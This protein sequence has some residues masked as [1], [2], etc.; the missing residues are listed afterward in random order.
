MAYTALLVRPCC[1]PPFLSFLFHQAIQQKILKYER[2]KVRVKSLAS[3]YSV[4]GSVVVMASGLLV[5]PDGQNPKPFQETF[6]LARH[7]AEEARF[8]VRNDMLRV[9]EPLAASATPDKVSAS[10]GPTPTKNVPTK[11]ARASDQPKDSKAAPSKQVAA[12]AGGAMNGVAKRK[13][14]RQRNGTGG[15][16]AADDKA[17]AS[18]KVCS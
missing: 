8:Y 3:Q 12:G 4:D 9:S 14:R 18:D 2:S 16:R 11:A 15:A 1:A 13:P 7:S 5:P 10:P 17:P 6:V